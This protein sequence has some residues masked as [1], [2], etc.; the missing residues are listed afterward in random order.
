MW[1]WFSYAAIRRHKFTVR[2][3]GS[4]QQVQLNRL[5]AAEIFPKPGRQ[6]G[7]RPQLVLK[8]EDRR[9]QQVYLPLG[10]WHAEHLLMARVL[11]ATVDCKVRIEGEPE[12]VRSFGGMIKAYRSW[13]HQQAAA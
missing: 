5:V 1:W 10:A 2:T 6:R 13:D 7:G 8:L 11:R 12:L 3:I 9:G 4:K